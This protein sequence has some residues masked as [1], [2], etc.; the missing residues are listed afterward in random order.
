MDA[1]QPQGIESPAIEMSSA[2]TRRAG[3]LVAVALASVL[4]FGIGMALEGAA[5]LPLALVTFNAGVEVGQVS[6]VCVLLAALEGVFRAT[7]EPSAR[8][9]LSGLL[10]LAG[11]WWLVSRLVGLAG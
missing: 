10:A 8:R 6:A 2:V 11:V 1:P 3:I 7:P 4:V 5:A 9:A